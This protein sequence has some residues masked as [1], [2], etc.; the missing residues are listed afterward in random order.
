MAYSIPEY[1]R[2][3]IPDDA[4]L[5]YLWDDTRV[6]ADFRAKTD[7]LVRSIAPVTLRAKI[8]LGI[9]IYE[10]IVWRFHGL[11]ADPLPIQ[12]AAGAWCANVDR[13]YMEYFEPGRQKWLGP[14]RGPLWCAMAALLPMIYFSD[15]STADWEYGLSFLPTLALHVLPE[16]SAF[17]GWL[18]ACTE[19]LNRLYPQLT[20]DIFADL[21]SE[22]QEKRRGPLVAREALDPDYPYTPDMAVP[23]LS[24]YLQTVDHGSNP[25]L[26]SSEKML[27]LGFEGIP[28]TL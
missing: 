28:Y 13:H 7:D 9:G 5:R 23:L 14:V 19:R 8:A 21:F 18:G 6:D 22:Q 15:D 1:I 17:K 4:P 16:D 12:L 26:Y 20:D 2:T 25:L 27:R 24:N 3:A 10:W 11:S